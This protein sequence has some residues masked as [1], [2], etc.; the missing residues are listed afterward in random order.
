MKL[1]SPEQLS[2]LADPE[3]RRLLST[4]GLPEMHVTSFRPVESPYPL[5]RD[6]R[7]LVFGTWDRGTIPIA[8]GPDGC[9]V[10]ATPWVNGIDPVN[11][12]LAAFL[13]CLDAVQRAAPFSTRNPN[14]ASHA[15]AADR[16]LELLG[17][18]DPDALEPDGF[19]WSLTED[20]KNGDYG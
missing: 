20:I 9:V 17:S 5:E 19:W 14:Y 2:R 10:S 3:A 7:Y 13:D 16:L 8:I 11:R 6:P 15:V 18:I 12:S 1:Y 4:R